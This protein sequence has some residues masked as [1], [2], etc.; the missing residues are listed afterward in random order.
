MTHVTYRVVAHDGGWAYKVGDVF[1]ETFA[2][3]DRA[4][5]A[6]TRAAREHKTPGEPAAIQYEDST[7]R[8]HEEMTRGNDRP[9]TDVTE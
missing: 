7:G 6:A 1:S 4:I 5:S 2:T 8:W 3:K 9:Y